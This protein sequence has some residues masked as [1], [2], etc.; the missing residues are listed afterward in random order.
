[1]FDWKTKAFITV[2]NLMGWCCIWC[3]DVIAE[4][5][6]DSTRKEYKISGL[7]VDEIYK[8]KVESESPLGVTAS[9]KYIEQRVSRSGKSNNPETVHCFTTGHN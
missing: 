5:K 6:I 7:L 1:M 4:I 8:V 3:A 9:S 2:I